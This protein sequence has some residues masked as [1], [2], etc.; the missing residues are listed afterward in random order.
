MSAEPIVIRPDT[1][2]WR[3]WVEFLTAR[4]D[5]A[6]LLTK[7]AR[8]ATAGRA[9]KVPREWPSEEA[10]QKA[11]Q[12]SG[13]ASP[14]APLSVGAR[15]LGYY[16]DVAMPLLDA[17][18]AAAKAGLRPSD[19]LV[20]VTTREDGPP[21]RETRWAAADFLAKAPA[22]KI[23]QHAWLEFERAGE[24]K[25]ATAVTHGILIGKPEALTEEA[26]TPYLQAHVLTRR[27][28]VRWWQEQHPEAGPELAEAALKAMS[29]KELRDA[30]LLMDMAG[31]QPAGTKHRVQYRPDAD[32]WRI[33]R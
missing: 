1:A 6:E 2:Q 22:L 19:R 26:C 15:W 13:A 5:K 16:G 33:Q 10:R 28:L 29:P 30:V 7:M 11:E 9:M 12:G 14:Q 17:Q 25:T 23:G 21:R 4:G 3:A 18:G 32:L 8:C 27:H 20:A 31:A 24:L